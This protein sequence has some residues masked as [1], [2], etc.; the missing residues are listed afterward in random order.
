VLFA[1]ESYLT[2]IV[3]SLD[4]SG[5]SG[6]VPRNL[7]GCVS[8]SGGVDS[9]DI[10]YTKFKTSQQQLLVGVTPRSTLGATPGGLC[11]V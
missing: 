6:Q 8:R 3:T 7:S 1:I 9:S 11:H 4:S 10:G 2:G 5:S